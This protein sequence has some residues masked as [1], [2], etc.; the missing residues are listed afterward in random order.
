MRG[1]GWRMAEQEASGEIHQA[2]RT[3]LAYLVAHPDA[4]DTIEG[5]AQWWAPSYAGSAEAVRRGVEELTRRGWLSVRT[6]GT[7]VRLYSLNKDLLNDV[8]RYL[9]G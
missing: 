4:K 6:G 1:M 3:I 7:G 2:I 5:I 8:T 9:H